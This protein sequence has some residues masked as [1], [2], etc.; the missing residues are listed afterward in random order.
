M[1][2]RRVVEY[3]QFFRAAYECLTMLLLFIWHSFTERDTW[4]CMDIGKDHMEFP[5]LQVYS[6]CYV[7]DNYL[8]ME[9]VN[10]SISTLIE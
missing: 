9:G 6:L 2:R 7:L 5:T 1:P 4:I 10:K 3:Q 8:H